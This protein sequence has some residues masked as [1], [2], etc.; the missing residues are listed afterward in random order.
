MTAVVSAEEFD[1]LGACLSILGMK[2][3]E[4]V[5]EWESRCGVMVTV[6]ALVVS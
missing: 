2:S 6:I 1:H 5:T 4:M 3:V